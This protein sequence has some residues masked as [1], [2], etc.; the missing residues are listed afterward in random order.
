MVDRLTIVNLVYSWKSSYY[1]LIIYCYDR[2]TIFVCRTF[3]RQRK[4]SSSWRL[5]TREGDEDDSRRACH[6][7]ICPKRFR[8]ATVETT[9]VDRINDIFT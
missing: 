9:W 7:A 5:V 4:R 3:S 6:T 1:D 2:I 8:L